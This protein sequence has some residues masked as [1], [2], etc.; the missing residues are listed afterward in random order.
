MQ[1]LDGE[2]LERLGSHDRSG[3]LSVSVGFRSR[4][5]KR[6][7]PVC[8]DVQEN[9]GQQQESSNAMIERRSSFLSSTRTC[10]TSQP[11][12]SSCRQA[13]RDLRGPRLVAHMYGTER[14]NHCSHENDHHEHGEV[15]CSG[16][17][18][19][20]GLWQTGSLA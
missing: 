1:D 11:S 3:N 18:V 8:N 16:K 20:V 17:S 15:G 9:E 2:I 4:C 6:T 12:R 13:V 10:I 5:L 19:S 14:L 7:S